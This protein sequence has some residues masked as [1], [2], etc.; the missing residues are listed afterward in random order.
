[1][2]VLSASVCLLGLVILFGLWRFDRRAEDF[3]DYL[4][5]QEEREAEYLRRTGFEVEL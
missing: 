4:D 5:R 1:M 3:F 2:E